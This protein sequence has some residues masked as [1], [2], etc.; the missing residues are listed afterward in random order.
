M[1]LLYSVAARKNQMDPESA[2][3]YFAT[4]QAAKVVEV[5]DLCKNCRA[6]STFTMGDSMGVIEALLEH[7]IEQLKV[8]NIVRLGGLGSLR[9]TINRQVGCDVE[10]EF[11][12][13]NIKGCHVLFTEG[14]DLSEMCQNMTYERTKAKKEEKKVAEKTNEQN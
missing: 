7:V 2:P 13:S 10:K 14:V 1:S 8:G 5:R 12:E 11:N 6:H 9:L 4:A 3:K